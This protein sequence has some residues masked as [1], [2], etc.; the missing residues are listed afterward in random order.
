MF[1]KKLFIKFPVF[2]IIL[3]I[4]VLIAW[5]YVAINDKVKE[6]I[7]LEA[8]SVGKIEE[9]RYFAEDIDYAPDVQEYKIT[10]ISKS[11]SGDIEPFNTV[12]NVQQENT[13]AYFMIESYDI[14]DDFKFSHF[15]IDTHNTAQIVS[16]I[17]LKIVS[18][19]TVTVF[20]QQKK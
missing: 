12:N 13:T 1:E 15:I 10:I 14:Y 8:D 9:L 7:K 3:G 11:I 4:F 2:I 19:V 6:F 5:S 18:D 20:Y 16:D 17:A